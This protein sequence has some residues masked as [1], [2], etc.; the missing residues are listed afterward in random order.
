M[1]LQTA[2]PMMVPIAIMM[3]GVVLQKQDVKEAVAELG[4]LK[5]THQIA[6]F[7]S[8]ATVPTISLAAVHLLC[9]REIA[10][11]TNNASKGLHFSAF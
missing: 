5:Q 8:G 7:R 9:V 2:A 4:F 3:S 1:I 6:A 10:S 11:G